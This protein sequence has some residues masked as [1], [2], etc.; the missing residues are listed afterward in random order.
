MSWHRSWRKTPLDVRLPREVGEM[1]KMR[2][3]RMVGVVGFGIRI[4]VLIKVTGLRG[5]H[6]LG[7][8]PVA[9]SR[10]LNR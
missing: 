6:A 9:F 3:M 2:K 7:K 1:G 10:L 4:R 8:S 5:R